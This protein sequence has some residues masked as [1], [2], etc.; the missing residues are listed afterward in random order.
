MYST[1]IAGRYSNKDGV[2][3]TTIF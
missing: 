2:G 3:K 1:D